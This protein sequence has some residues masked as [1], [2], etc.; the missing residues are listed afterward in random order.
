MLN[1]LFLDSGNTS[2]SLIAESILRATGRGRFQAHSAGCV[3]VGT[4]SAEVLAFLRERNLPAEGL[5]S[6]GLRELAGP[7][8]QSFA[9]IIT[10][11][12]LAAAT[13]AERTFPG[14]PVIAH[15]P[16]D[17]EE[18]SER[19]PSV[20]ALRDSYWILSRRIKIF[21]SLPHGKASRHAL[22]NRL[23][24]LESWQ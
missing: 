6:K 8:S 4:I 5:R 14:D 16:L 18:E 12:D 7:E 3:S 19:E 20:W 17:N 10:L 21:T 1:V 11:S 24:A 13:T 23:H 22:E 2:Y 9:F 15:W